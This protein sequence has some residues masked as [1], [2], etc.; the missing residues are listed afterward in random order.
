MTATWRATAPKIAFVIR[1]AS[2]GRSGLR[3]RPNDRLGRPRAW[4]S[5][6]CSITIYTPEGAPLDIFGAAATGRCARISTSR[7]PGRDRAPTSPPSDGT[8]VVAPHA[9]ARRR[10]RR[11]AAASVRPRSGRAA[12]TARL[13]PLRRSTER[14]TN[15]DRLG[16]GRRD[17][18]PVKQGGLAAQQAD[19]VAEEI[20]ARAGAD[21]IRSRSG[22]CC[23]ASC[24][25]DAGR[26]GC[27]RR[28]RDGE[29]EAQRRAL[30][31]PPTKI[32]GRYLSPYLAALDR[33]QAIGEVPQPSGHP[34]ELDLDVD[35]HRRGRW[36]ARRRGRAAHPESRRV[37]VAR[38][39]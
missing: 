34:V 4:A 13:H 8:L 6:T 18:Y 11:G 1:P 5:T 26:H 21:V 25:P 32:A 33:M 30:F 14:S 10:P 36:P 7:D 29:G 28:R 17:R 15:R 3:A 37:M 35:C 39:R 27:E 19:A 24:S 16:G 9:A 2:P 31:W 38:T 12:T 22:P 23:A 20:A